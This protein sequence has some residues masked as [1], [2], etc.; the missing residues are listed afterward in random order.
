[1]L[2]VTINNNFVNRA[3]LFANFLWRQLNL[4]FLISFIG[5]LNF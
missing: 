4:I 2:L 5:Q 3:I 1:M